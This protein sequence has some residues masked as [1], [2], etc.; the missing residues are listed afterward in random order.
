MGTPNKL[1]APASRQSPDAGAAQSAHETQ[2]PRPAHDRAAE[3]GAR[4]EQQQQQQQQ[5]AATVADAPHVLLAEDDR[6][7]RRYLEVVLRRAG[8]RV[9]AAADGLEALQLALSSDISAVVTDAVMPRLGGRELCRLLRARA[10]LA[11]LPLVLL[12]GLDS[13][14]QDSAPGAQPDARLTKPVDSG[15]LLDCLARLLR[16]PA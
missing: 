6:A 3:A 14:A 11:S 4:A 8:Y 7:L 9:T 2:P 13:G 15:E 12:T 1:A 16:R 5:Q 10:E